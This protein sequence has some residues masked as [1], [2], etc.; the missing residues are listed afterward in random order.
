MNSAL[1]LQEVAPLPTTG[2]ARKIW[3]LILKSAGS[4]VELELLAQATEH[5]QYS[6]LCS[7]LRASQPLLFV[8]PAFPAKSSNPDKTLGILPDMGEWLGLAKL[9]RLM[10]EISSLYTP[11]AR[12]LICSDGRVFSDLVGVEDAHVDLY[13]GALRVLVEQE[14]FN[15]IDFFALEDMFGHLDGTAM[16]R[17]LVIN[18]ADSPDVIR[19]QILDDENERRLFNGVHRFVFEDRLARAE[20]YSRNKLRQL[21]KQTAYEVIQRSH[22][23]S[24]L[25]EKKFPSAIRLSIHPQMAQAPK[26]GFQL[27]PSDN[28]WRTPWHSV[29]LYQDGQFRLVS[30]REARECGGQIK[31]H[32]SLYPYF[33]V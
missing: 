14:N 3:A 8:L 21:T 5:R 12:V 29:A 7:L 22:A 25:V 13:G 4:P 2:L 9:Q 31:L 26:L 27:V 24:R 15:R 10:E 33:E 23:W 1:S 32:R 19:E 20:A 6:Q 11:G 30:H 16:R 28:R 18:Y 17:E